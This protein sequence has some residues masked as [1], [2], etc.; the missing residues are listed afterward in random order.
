MATYIVTFR[1]QQFSIGDFLIAL[2]TFIIV[3]VVVFLIVKIAKRWH[4]DQ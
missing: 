3:V 1:K 4:M 2:I